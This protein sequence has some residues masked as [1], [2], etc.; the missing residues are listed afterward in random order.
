MK[1]VCFII[2]YFG[3]LPNYFPLFLK[4]CRTNPNYNWLIITDDRTAYDYPSNVKIV[5]KSFADLKQFIQTKFDFTISLNS[6]YKLCDYKPAYGYL[7]EEYIEGFLFW[8]HCD[9]DI[10]LGN[11]NDFISIDKICNYDKIYQL[12]HMT[13]YRNTFELNRIFRNK[14]NNRLIYKEAFTTDKI[15]RFDEVGELNHN[16]NIDG[17]YR[18]EHLRIYSVDH[19]LN[20]NNRKIAFS[21][22]TYKGKEEYPSEKGFEIEKTFRSIVLWNHGYIE[23]YYI[24]EGR[25]IISKHPYIHLQSR[26]MIFNSEVLNAE[27]INIIPN[28]FR[29]FSFKKVTILNFFFITTHNRNLGYYYAYA[30]E[31]WLSIKTIIYYLLKGK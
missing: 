18:K 25:L 16:N 21:R 9:L 28:E 30:K 15:Y 2:P 5:Y 17:I 13:L 8:G 10:I 3:T 11:L 14:L 26:K 22:V 19:S 6:P 27:I 23:R 7:F 24:C 1:N 31:K 4:S 12:G 29:V 20:I